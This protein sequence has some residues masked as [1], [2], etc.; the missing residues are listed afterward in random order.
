MFP[1]TTKSFKE[2][3]KKQ[4]ISASNCL[5]EDENNNNGN[6]ATKI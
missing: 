5:T 1:E 4:R 3:G 2:K 6:K